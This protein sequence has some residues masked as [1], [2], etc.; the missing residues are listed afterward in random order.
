LVSQVIGHTSYN[1][2]L[3]RVSPIFVAICL[4]GE[5]IIGGFLGLVYFNEAIPAMT[6]LGGV[7]ILVGLWCAIRAEMGRVG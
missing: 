6:L 1:H 5:P 3:G 7:P 4:L 2:S